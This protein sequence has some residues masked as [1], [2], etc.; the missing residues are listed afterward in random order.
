MHNYG[1]FQGI[2]C[3]IS[4]KKSCETKQECSF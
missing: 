1:D 2:D 4:L 3:F